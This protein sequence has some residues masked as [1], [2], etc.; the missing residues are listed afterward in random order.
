MQLELEYT[1]TPDDL[2]EYQR[3]YSSIAASFQGNKRGLRRFSLFAFA[4][5]A[6]AVASVFFVFYTDKTRPAAGEQTGGW[7]L[8]A[9]VVA[10]VLAW[11]FFF[12]RARYS[13]AGVRRVFKDSPDLA[14]VQHVT[15]SE[16]GVAVRMATSVTNMTW[17]HFVHFAESAGLYLLFVSKTA[18]HIIPKRAFGSAAEMEWFRGV[19]QAR[20]GK[21]TGGFPV[22]AAGGGV[23]GGGGQ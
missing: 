11:F 10:M 23:G 1:L 21:A 14:G 3:A 13:K 16:E 19:A 8:P 22:A 12:V 15:V 9:I 20:A 18:A 5:L 4:V 17:A 2:F 7:Q 6:S